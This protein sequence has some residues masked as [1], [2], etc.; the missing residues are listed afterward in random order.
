MKYFSMFSGI[1]GFE[2][3]IEDE[4]SNKNIRSTKQQESSISRHDNMCIGSQPDIRQQATCIGFSEIDKNAINIY[5]KHYPGHKN[6]GDANEIR[7]D[8]LPDFDLLVGGFP[9]QAFSIAGKRRGFDEARGTLFFEIARILSDKRPRNFLLENV[10]GLLSHD[11]GETFKTIIKVLTNIGYC[12]EWQV[13]NSKDFGVPQNRERVFIV[14]HLGVECGRKIFPITVQSNEN[15]TQCESTKAA[16]ARTLACGGHSA[17]NHSG[18]T[19]IK[20]TQSLPDAQ[21]IRDIDGNSVTLKGLGGGQGAKTGLY[22]IPV[23]TPDRPEKRQN[24]RRFKTDGEEGTAQ[25]IH[26][27]FDGYRIRRL[28]PIE[29]E[30][31]QGFDKTENHVIMQVC[32]DHQKSHASAEEKNL[33]SPS[34][35]GSVESGNVREIVLSAEKVLDLSH[36]QINKH[37]QQSVLINCEES[38]VEILYQGKSLLSV[39]NAEIPISCPPHIKTEDFAHLCVG[40]YSM[41]E[42]EIT[43]GKA[44]S[45]QSEQCSTHQKNGEKLVKLSGS[46]IMQRADCVEKGLTTHKELLRFITLSHSPTESLEQRLAILSL[47]VIHAISGYI[48]PKIKSQNSFTIIIKNSHGWTKYGA[49][50][51]KMSDSARYK[52]CG[53]AVTTNVIRAI[54][55]NLYKD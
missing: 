7:T 32:L 28:T 19:I 3:G 1:G 43:S 31:L 15:T 2:K 54:I 41:L 55:E 25:D 9:C 35:V 23:L 46:E 12:V 13:L 27:V 48:P 11:N 5:K 17:G 18:M 45:L 38:R 29:C 34:C 39:N 42:R 14:G 10:K 40:L 51:K 52:V 4:F 49:D 50:G 26:G 47:Y 16:V 53:N 6:Y 44:G 8:E 33:K 22:A 36:P 37:V 21:I 24:G 20:Q 30:R